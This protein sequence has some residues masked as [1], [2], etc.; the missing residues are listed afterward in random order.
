MKIVLS[1]GRPTLGPFGLGLFFV[2]GG[3]PILTPFL[4]SVGGFG[5]LLRRGC[6]LAI[7]KDI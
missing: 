6:S 5:G 1:D 3:L 4:E 2:P 7:A